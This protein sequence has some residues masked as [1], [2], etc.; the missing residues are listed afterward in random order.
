MKNRT[1][2]VD[3]ISELEMIVFH[4]ASKVETGASYQVRVIVSYAGGGE[5]F[6]KEAGSGANCKAICIQLFTTLE[7]KMSHH[8]WLV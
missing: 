3:D 8:K 4:L 6:V 7:Y 1:N 5:E 2:Y